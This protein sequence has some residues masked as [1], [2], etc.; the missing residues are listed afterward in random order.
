MK[1]GGG[2]E[3]GLICEELREGVMGQYGKNTL[4]EILRVNYINKILY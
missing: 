4:Y 2:R 3:T 1:L